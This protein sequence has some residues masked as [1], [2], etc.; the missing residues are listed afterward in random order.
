MDNTSDDW[1]SPGCLLD[2]Y[3]QDFPSLIPLESK[4][5]SRFRV[6][7]YR[8]PLL[9]V[10]ILHCGNQVSITMRFVKMWTDILKRRMKLR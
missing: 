10:F 7:D 6:R 2:T 9:Q 5:L 1:T 4:E 8:N 3:L